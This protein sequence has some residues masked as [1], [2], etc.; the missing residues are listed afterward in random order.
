MTESEQMLLNE[1]P[2]KKRHLSWYFS[3]LCIGAGVFIVGVGAYVAGGAF[4]KLSFD[5]AKTDVIEKR[6]LAVCKTAECQYRCVKAFTISTASN[7]TVFL[8]NHVENVDNCIRVISNAGETTV[9]EI[10]T[11][12]PTGK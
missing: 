5:T 1:G 3:W 2:K 9:G 10:P 6:C 11:I 4:G 12:G 7:V 8:D